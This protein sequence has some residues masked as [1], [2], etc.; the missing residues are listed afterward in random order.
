MEQVFLDNRTFFQASW[1][2]ALNPELQS[3]CSKVMEVAWLILSVVVFPI[4]LIRLAAYE[5]RLLASRLIMMGPR[6]HPDLIEEIGDTLL[7]SFPN[8]EKVAITT[9]DGCVLDGVFFPSNFAKEGQPKKTILYGFGNAASWE[10]HSAKE[11][12]DL[13]MTG[14]DVIII[15]PRGL[16]KST[17]DKDFSKLPLDIYA[18]SDF[19]IKQKKVDPDNLLYHTFSLSGG[20]MIAGAAL[21]Q[22]QYPLSKIK[23]ISQ[24]S[25]ALLSKEVETFVSNLLASCTCCP[26]FIGATL[27]LL[28]RAVGAEIDSKAAWDKLKGR[29]CV[30]YSKKDDVVFYPVSLRK[31]IVEDPYSENCTEIALYC[32]YKG[33]GGH[34]DHP[35]CAETALFGEIFKL[36][37]LE[38]TEELFQKQAETI[39]E[40]PGCLHQKVKKIRQIAV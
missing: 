7:E 13:L 33:W 29:K 6:Y 35:Q 16:I 17:G 9:P 21:V 10:M 31:A 30:T 39:V 32:E 34:N 2:D 23:A 5:I 38:R 11:V 12:R 1:P 14:A 28:I 26:N 22:E 25:F 18:I 19:L 15:N 8:H 40:H 20:Y 3:I 27:G 37:E 4:G 24:C 36:L